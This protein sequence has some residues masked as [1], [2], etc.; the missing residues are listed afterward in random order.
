MRIDPITPKGMDK[1]YK[2][3]QGKTDDQTKGVSSV[4][5]AELTEDAQVFSSALKAAK[6]TLTERTPEQVG[7]IEQ[8]A[9]QIKNNTY[10]VSGRDIAKKMLDND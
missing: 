8:V 9:E 10:N 7:R 4:D 6:E 1:Q 3:V 5:K 2:F